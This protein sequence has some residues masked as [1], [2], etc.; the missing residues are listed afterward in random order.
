MNITATFFYKILS[1]GF[2][3]SLSFL[4]SACDFYACYLETGAQIHPPT[5]KEEVEL[6]LTTPDKTYLVIGAVTANGTSQEKALNYLKKR[7]TEIGAD[8]VIQLKLDEMASYSPR[9]NVSGVAV[10]FVKN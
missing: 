3:I 2:L 10:K 4:F 5:Q 6:Y 9:I 7:V 1:L 8:A